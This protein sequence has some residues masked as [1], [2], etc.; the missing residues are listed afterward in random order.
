MQISSFS[1]SGVVSYDRKLFNARCLLIW[2]FNYTFP[3]ELW[4][5]WFLVETSLGI[6]IAL[7]YLLMNHFNW[8]HIYNDAF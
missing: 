8:L 6:S 5:E 3:S 4:K 7:T 2:L 1:E